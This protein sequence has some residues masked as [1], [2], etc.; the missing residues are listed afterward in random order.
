MKACFF[1]PDSLHRDAPGLVISFDLENHRS[2]RVLD[3]RD[4]RACQRGAV[5]VER[6]GQPHVVGADRRASV[7]ILDE[8][9]EERV[10]LLPVLPHELFEPT[11]PLG[12]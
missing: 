3:L 7:G 2:S 1:D 9:P 12:R 6:H 10:R 5:V 4:E 11:R 8:E